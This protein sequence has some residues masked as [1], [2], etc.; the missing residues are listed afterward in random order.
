LSL[1]RLSEAFEDR[2]FKDA[3]EEAVKYENTLFDKAHH[4]WPNLLSR[5]KEG[6]LG[7]WNAWCHGAPGIGLA[8]LG[9][10]SGAEEHEIMRDINE[11]IIAASEQP[12]NPVDHLCCGTLGRLDTL[13]EAGLRLGRADLLDRA[14]RITAQIV[15]R[16]KARKAYSI[17]HHDTFYIPSFF[18]GMSGIGYQ[19]LRM[20]APLKFASVLNFQ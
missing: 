1:V 10:I 15:I 17:G 5:N 14:R 3:A 6:K 18:Q 7:F 2:R 12:L 4:N 8:R 20:S 13:V 11:S 9:M 16:A 19:L